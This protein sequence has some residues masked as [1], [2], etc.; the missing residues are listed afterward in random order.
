MEILK[1]PFQKVN[2][3]SD[4]DIAYAT[5]NAALRSFYKYD[6][7]L[8][9]FAEVIADK[10]KDQTNRTVLVEVL[11]E[12]YEKFPTTEAVKANIEAL[13]EPNTFTVIT[14]HQP[15]LCTGPLYYIYKIASAI[16][17]SKQL[18]AQYADH[19]IVPV[20]VTGGEDHDFEEVNH[21]HLFGKTYTWENEES[22][23]VGLMKTETLQP[24]LAELKDTLGDLETAQ[25]IFLKIEKAYTENEFYGDAAIQLTNDLFQDYGLVVCGMNH[26]KLKAQMI[27]VIEEE[28]FEQPSKG[29][30]EKAQEALEDAGFSG[31]A[32]AR[33][34]NFFY[35]TANRRSRIVKEGESYKVL[36]TDLSFSEAALRKEIQEHPERFSPNVIMRPIYQE[37]ILPNLAY[38][39]GGG[40]IAYWL[41]RKAQFAHFKINFPM[42][43]RRNSVLWIDKGSAKKMKKLD[44]SLDELLTETE[45]LIKHFVK[46]NTE[47]EIS[48]AEEKNQLLAIFEQVK[49]KVA[50]V[51]QTLV[52]TVMAEHAKQEKSLDQLQGRIMR[53]E[54]QRF[55]ISLNQIRSLKDKL[56]PN[57]GLQERHDNFLNF[58]LKYGPTFFETLIEHLNPLDKAEM[59]VVIDG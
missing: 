18:N 5:E 1:I 41:E 51:D 54:K 37:L 52:K 48:L 42:L 7:T 31:Q 53:A 27:P 50:D 35:L 17:L 32:H 3:F 13:L 16:N 6:V 39:G 44:L 12:Q 29:F 55:D 2:A 22:G 58:Y 25:S 34:I 46:E 19:H 9:A 36:D 24:V 28:I 14:A 15:S 47:N 21:F 20:F 38:I 56:F 8:D 40:E 57:N 23:A 11:R 10:K 59:V 26:Q 4:K 33:D 30:V 49:E 43:I 45:T